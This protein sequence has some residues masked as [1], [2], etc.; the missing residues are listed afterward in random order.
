MTESMPGQ[1]T[2]VLIMAA[3]TGGHVFPALSIAQKLQER[4]VRTEW[5]GT[6]QGMENRLLE[7]TGIRIHAVSA[8]G[9]KGKG[10]AR[11]IT[12]PFMLIQALFQSMRV[13][14]QV[15]PDCV[16]GMGGFVSGPGGLAAKL[17]GRKLVIHEQNA[18]PG[19]TNK[20]LAKIAN[21]VF[22]AFPN[23]FN[24][25]KKVMHTGNPIR[26]EIAALAKRPRSIGEPSE[27]LRILVLGGSQGALAINEIVPV[28]LAAMPETSRPQVRHQAGEATLQRTRAIYTEQGLGSGE[29]VVPFIGDMAEAYGWA[30][31]IICRSGASTVSEIAA[32]GLPSILVPYPHHSDRQQTHNANWLVSA[33]AAFLL[34]QEDLSFDALSTLLHDLNADRAKLQEMSDIAKSIAIVD[35]DDLIATRCLELA[36]A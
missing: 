19:A 12:A 1:D 36:H 23:T 10:L 7:G 3:G 9:L 31:L 24:S 5:M 25:S 20:L 13:L 28:V 18:V 21:Q 17:M 34:E 32:V 16:L 8:K 30:D 35:A 2:T 11:L 15:N 33:G 14:S 27:R 4:D 29:E 26:R 6:H 22:E